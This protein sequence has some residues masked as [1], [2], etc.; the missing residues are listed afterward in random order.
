MLRLA[1][2]PASRRPPLSSNVRPNM[3]PTAQLPS[4]F[5]TLAGLAKFIAVAH[6]SP[7]F[8]QQH[9]HAI[10][11]TCAFLRTAASLSPAVEAAFRK[12]L[13]MPVNE[14]ATVI[15]AAIREA[16]LSERDVQWLDEQE[17]EVL[18]MLVPVV[19]APSLPQWLAESRWAVLGAFESAQ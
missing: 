17:T 2:K 19:R 9:T 6:I 1:A 13:P 14:G 11:F 7:E 15:E 3:P 18:Q 10:E 8:Y 16:A 4:A 5:E 12:S